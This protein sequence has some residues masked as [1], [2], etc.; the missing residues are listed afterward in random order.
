[1]RQTAIAAFIRQ[2]LRARNLTLQQ[3]RELLGYRSMTSLTRI[4]QGTVN[5]SSLVS[6][7]EKIRTCS[8]ISLSKQENN[9]LDD[10]IELHDIGNKDFD[11]MIAL[12]RV[13]RGE[14][15]FAATPQLMLYDENGCAQSILTHYGAV[16]LKKVLILNSEHVPVYHDLA[17]MMQ[18]KPFSVEHWIYGSNTPMH[19]VHS[20]HAAIPL[21]YNPNFSSYC[22]QLQN[23]LS[24]TRGLM[25]SDLMLCEYLDPKGTLRHEAVIFTDGSVGQVQ[26]ISLSIQQFMRF[27][28]RLDV[29]KPN[30]EIVSSS[31]MLAYARFCTELEHERAVYRIKPDLGIDQIPVSILRQA[32]MD[33]APPYVQQML[34]VLTEQFEIRQNNSLHKKTPQHHVMKKGAM[35]KFVHTGHTSDHLWCCRDFSM[36]ER[37]AIL[38]Y[39]RHDLMNQAEFHIHFLKD[40]DVIRDDEFVLYEGRGLSL[41]IPGT[42]YHDANSHAEVLIT[43]EE[44]LEVFRRFYVESTLRY[45]VETEADSIQEIDRMIAYCQQFSI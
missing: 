24:H 36:Q 45:R 42:D 3:L 20:L 28:P 33:G 37:L 23:E 32:V 34:P 21:L 4:M 2:L 44:L 31:D 15:A 26:Q 43:H 1:M 30:R 29:M 27:L 25:T 19:T 9:Q 41:I 13:L 35:W 40:D 39:L 5:R 38:R 14:P 16:T 11:T 17:L 6:F 8:D 22:F 18:Q 10:L 12:R 7:A